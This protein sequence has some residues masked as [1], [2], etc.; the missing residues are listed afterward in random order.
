MI[1]Y[2]YNG[3]VMINHPV[4]TSR[5]WLNTTTVVAR[6]EEHHLTHADFADTSPTLGGLTEAQIWDRAPAGGEP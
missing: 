2:A 5:F 6:L 4:A 3:S 1:V